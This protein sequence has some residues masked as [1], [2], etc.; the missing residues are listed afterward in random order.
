[1]TDKMPE[2]IWIG[3]QAHATFPQ[4]HEHIPCHQYTLTST[5]TAKLEAAVKMAEALC[6]VISDHDSHIVIDVAIKS[7][8]ESIQ[9]WQRANEVK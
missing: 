5:V 1:M 9:N 6:E 7:A 8:K 3:E 4:K 2:N